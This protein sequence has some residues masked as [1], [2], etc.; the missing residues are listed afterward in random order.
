M[1]VVKYLSATI[2]LM[3]LYAVSLHLVWAVILVFD[4]SAINATAVNAL[5]R[6]VELLG[7][8]EADSVLLLTV[9]VCSVALC[10][11]VALT[12]HHTGR[13][14]AWILLLLVPQQAVLFISAAGAIDAIWN[15][16]FADGVIR[17]RGF[18]AA[19][20]F[21]SILAALWHTLAIIRQAL[22]G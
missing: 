19:D 15:A 7:W 4:S 17:D 20:Q 5:Y 10:A 16:Q 2:S 13:A 12:L 14:R 18:I 1:A 21:Y 22:R 3:V 8:P 9:L 11:L 6:A